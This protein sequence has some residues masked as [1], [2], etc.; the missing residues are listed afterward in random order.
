MEPE[1]LALFFEAARPFLHER[2]RRLVAARLAQSLGIGGVTLVAR[3][4][5][6]ARST[7][8]R[9]L[10]ELEP[11][12]APAGGPP[13]D[14]AAPIRRPGGGRKPAD[15]ADPELAASLHA[16]VDP[17]TRGDPQSPLLWVSKSTRHLADVLRAQGHAVSHETVRQL[18]RKLR[19][20]LQANRKTKEGAQHPDRNAQ[21]EFLARQT[22]QFLDAEQPAISVDTKK[23]ELIGAYANAGREWRPQGQPE[24]VSV[25]DFPD[26]KV[27]K[28][29][30]YGVYDLA[31]DEGW[32]S[33]GIT[34]DTAEFAVETIR[35]WWIRMGSQRY[36]GARHLM[37]T[38]DAGGSNSARGRLWKQCLQRLADEF[39]LRLWV[40]HYPPGTSKWN[41]IEHRMFSRITEN[42]RGR[43]LTSLEVIVN[44]I[45]NARL[46]KGAAIRAEPDTQT[47]VKGKRVSKSALA[48]VRLILQEF[49]PDWNYIIVPTADCP[50]WPLP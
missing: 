25:H 14:L 26:P 29:V 33:V 15:V 30:P 22:Q 20:R 10:A 39:D 49:H 40:C 23:K 3:A 27:G 31:A 6:L 43:P 44:L 46:G 38:A 16:L 5:G 11:R 37:I 34:A 18:L 50:V 19:F 36:P 42:W 32:V 35:R 48:D 8:D 47:Y 28:A 1:H 2:A 12:P 21:F 41:K 13:E 9:G 45:G 17:V 24:A 4:S 7:I